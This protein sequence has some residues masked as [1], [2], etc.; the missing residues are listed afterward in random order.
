[1]SSEPLR[2]VMVAVGLAFAIPLSAQMPHGSTERVSVGSDGSQ[3]DSGSGGD[4]SH[5]VAVSAEG[6][7]VAFSSCASNL[8]VDDTNGECDVFVRD[9][10]TK[11]TTRVSVASDGVQAND[12]SGSPAISG[13]GRYVAFVSWANNLVANDTN[14]TV[15]VFVHDRLTAATTRDSVASDGRQGNGGSGPVS[16][17]ADGRF[18]A[19]TSWAS[20]LVV[21]D[22]NGCAD[23]I[24]RD[25]AS[26]ATTRVSVATGGTQADHGSDGSP[27]ISAD[28]RYVAFRSFGSNLVTGDTNGQLDVFVHDRSTAAT[29]RVSVASDGTQAN[30]PSGSPAVSGDGRVVGFDSLA[31]NLVDGDTNGSWDVFAHDRT[32]G[33]TTRVSVA[34]DGA[35]GNWSSFEPSL[36]PD[37]RL[38]AF[39]SHSSNLVA[40]DTNGCDDV[41]LHD[42]VTGTTTRVS[43]AT[44]LTQGGGDSRHAAVTPDGLFVAFASDAMN[45]VQGD[46]NH[47]LDVFIRDRG[48]PVDPPAALS[49]GATGSGVAMAWTAPAGGLAPTGYIVEAGSA[50]GLCDLA[51]ISTGTA[52]TA[53]TANGVGAGTYYL[54]VR[55]MNA[56]WVSAPSDEVSIQVG[57]GSPGG[58]GAPGAP[59]GLAAGASGSS[60]TMSWTAPAI[61]GYPSSY[62]IEAGSATGLVDLARIATGNP[63]T[64]FVATGVWNGQYFLRVRATNAWGTSAPSNERPVVVD[65]SAPGAPSGLTWSA[66]GSSLSMRWNPPASGEVPAAYTVEAGSAPGLS[67]VA[68]F[69]TASPATSYA[70]SAVA[71]GTYFVRVKAANA[72]GLSASSNEVTLV[73]GCMAAPGPPGAA[74]SQALWDSSGQVHL[75]WTPPTLSPG[76]SNGHT[77]YLVE[78]GSSPGLSNL[79]VFE[80]NGSETFLHF[81]GVPEGV[82]YVRVKARNACGLSAPSNELRVV[83]YYYRP[84][85]TP[86]DPLRERQIR[87]G[88]ALSGTSPT[89]LV[90]RPARV[91]R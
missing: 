76:S 14:G 53:F 60:V 61:G 44:D 51:T 66:A 59:Q 77:A 25:R 26:G 8:V 34:T 69:S 5:D 89:P 15:D 24:V 87:G 48:T 38:V 19:F 81:L 12:Y 52:L 75:V 11:E 80:V 47:Y 20:N 91:R 74:Q 33:V 62:L 56:E 78:A 36:T 73:V 17:S 40:D 85:V 88:S 49:A 79:G 6:R 3:G 82:Y 2:V 90:A 50:Q 31:S 43:V 21:G 22:T 57:G 42:M 28:G 10:I 4:A 23:T 63:T 39:D 83:M 27:A 7:Y 18:V 37:G 65:L 67:D 72:V 54:R 32:T 45:L 86:T 55:A 46:T 68:A 16:L 9:R 29:T 35:Q 64:S 1:M 30:G 13:D 71:N 70:V 41:F 84:Q 58:P